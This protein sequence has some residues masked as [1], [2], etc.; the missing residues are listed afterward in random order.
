MVGLGFDVSAADEP[1]GAELCSFAPLDSSELWPSAD[2][3]ALAAPEDGGAELCSAAPLEVSAEPVSGCVASCD[4]SGD[5]PAPVGDL[6][7]LFRR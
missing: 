5:T 1:S 3:W 4:A 6:V 7:E 2:F